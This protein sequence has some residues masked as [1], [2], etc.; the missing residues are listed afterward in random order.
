MFIYLDEGFIHFS[1]EQKD[2][3]EKLGYQIQ[4]EPDLQTEILVSSRGSDL[5]KVEKL[6]QLK[7]IQ[8][9]S[10]GYDFFDV[11]AIKA[12]DIQICNARG[13]YSEAI[14]EFVVARILEIYQKLPFI[15]KLQSDKEWFRDFELQTISGLKGAILGTGSIAQETGKLL[16]VFGSH[17]DGYNTSGNKPTDDFDECYKLK[18][19]DNLASSY[20]F[21][22]ITLPLNE[23]TKHYFNK[24]RLLSL[25]PEAVLVNIARGPIVSEAD[26]IE[27]LDQHLDAVILDVFENEPLSNESPLWNHPKTFISPHISFRNIKYKENLIDLILEN[28]TLYS[29]GKELLNQI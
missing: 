18:E 4:N 6:G 22:V 25:K 5:K 11:D 17:I 20:D 2:Y 9:M 23:H 26:L 24:E 15:N 16:K 10:A 27:I 1:Q 8:L 29:K 3:I 13:V 7:V 19:F 12:R 28:L 14:A 21:V